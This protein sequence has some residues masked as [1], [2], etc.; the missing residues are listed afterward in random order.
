MR[1]PTSNT[2][3]SSNRQPPGAT[4]V[5][6]T[7]TEL[8]E[9]FAVL[10]S[11]HGKLLRIEAKQGVEALAQRTGAVVLFSLVLTAGDLLACAALTVAL[12]P[13]VPAVATLALLA[14]LHV[15]A[16]AVGLRWALLR[17]RPPLFDDSLRELSQSARA[18]AAVGPP[19]D[20]R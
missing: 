17:A 18:L 19:V 4:S 12:A 6:R 10:V 8:A 20:G 2:P 9:S 3:A 15:L 16:G 13:T 11:E 14:A 1:D 7:F 5:S